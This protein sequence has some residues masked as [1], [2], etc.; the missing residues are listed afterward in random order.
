MQANLD[1]VHK[2]YLKGRRRIGKSAID[3]FA[4]WSNRMQGLLKPALKRQYWFPTRISNAALAAC[5]EAIAI[6]RL[7]RRPGGPAFRWVNRSSSWATARFLNISAERQQCIGCSSRDRLRTI[8][9][10]GCS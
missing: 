8:I 9:A 4:Y 3:T 6:Q 5:R 10:W 7:R 1:A 2:E